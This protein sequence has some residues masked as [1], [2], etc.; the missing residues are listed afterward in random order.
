MRKDRDQLRERIIDLAN[1]TMDELDDLLQALLQA[2]Y[3]TM[4]HQ[5]G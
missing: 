1:A 2:C 5:N 4:E 3:P